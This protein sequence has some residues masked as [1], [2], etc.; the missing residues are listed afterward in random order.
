MNDA[1]I[2]APSFPEPEP[3]EEI[4]ALAMWETYQRLLNP[5]IPPGVQLEIKKGFYSGLHSIL[6][7]GEL[8][9]DHCKP[10]DAARRMRNLREEL[11][12]EIVDI[13]EEE[14][15]MRQTEPVDKATADWKLDLS[16]R[17]A[18]QIHQVIGNNIAFYRNQ[19]AV[20]ITVV[21]DR[22]ADRNKLKDK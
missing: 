8:I 4:S 7:A 19:T 13:I 6:Q 20:D 15:I 14:R 1:N 11:E 10:D 22:A 21:I 2:P 17:C 16:L 5:S 9:Y 18:H 12:E 3:Q